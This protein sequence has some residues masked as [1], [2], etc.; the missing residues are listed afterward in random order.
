MENKTEGVRRPTDTEITEVFK[1][2]QDAA[3]AFA[4]ISREE[5]T[6][7]GKKEIARNKLMQARE[8]KRAILEDLTAY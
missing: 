8:A 2:E 4:R 6:L 7:Q 3:L 5:T 1:A